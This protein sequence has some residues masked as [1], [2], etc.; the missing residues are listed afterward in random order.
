MTRI[1]VT[2]EAG[3]WKLLEI[4]EEELHRRVMVG[5]LVRNAF[6]DAAAPQKFPV[7]V[8]VKKHGITERE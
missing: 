2:N 7:F 4:S 6:L 8:E 1:M 3:D 5:E